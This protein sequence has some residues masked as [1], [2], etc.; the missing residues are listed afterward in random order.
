MPRKA[1][2]KKELGYELCTH[3][4]PGRRCDSPTTRCLLWKKEGNSCRRHAGSA[5]QHPKCVSSGI[6]PQS[7]CLGRDIRENWQGVRNATAAELDLLPPDTPSSDSEMEPPSDCEMEPPSGCEMEPPTTLHKDEGR[8]TTLRDNEDRIFK[9]LFI[10]D[11]TTRIASKAAAVNDLAFVTTTISEDE[12][13]TISHL[14]GYVHIIKSY[15]SR[16]SVCIQE[17]VM[18]LV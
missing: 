17:W 10:L 1:T 12:L 11:P 8:T 7:V 2:Y 18:Y 14:D 3:I 5:R 4:C 13:D 16:Y 9:I 15:K 6:C